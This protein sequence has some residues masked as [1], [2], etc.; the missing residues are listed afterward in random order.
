MRHTSV[1][2]PDC[3][4]T[5]SGR[6]SVATLARAWVFRVHRLATVATLIVLP[7]DVVTADDPQ[8]AF[9][10]NTRSFLNSHCVK[11]HGTRVQ[12]ADLTLHDLG[13]NLRDAQT[14]A[15]WQRVFEQVQLDNMPPEDERR[16]NAGKR[17]AF[18]E[19]LQFELAHAGIELDNERLLRPEFGNYV[20][21]DKLF[22]GSI[23]ALPATVSRVWLNKNVSDSSPGEFRDF[24]ALKRLDEATT[25]RDLREIEKGLE[26]IIAAIK[27]NKRWL[28]GGYPMA[29]IV[30]SRH[31]G[32]DVI[33]LFGKT[34]ASREVIEAD[35]RRAFEAMRRPEPS[36]EQL[37]YYA[38][39]VQRV[40]E[41]RGNEAGFRALLMALALDPS[42]LYRSELGRGEVD[43]H[44][45]RML[46]VQEIE[47][48]Y[49][50]RFGRN[51]LYRSNSE[52]LLH[53][54]DGID[55]VARHVVDSSSAMNAYRDFFRQY[56]GYT[57]ALDVFKGE[58]HARHHLKDKEM[59]AVLV[60]ELEAMI[61]RTLVEDRDVL[62]R[63]LTTDRIFVT[64]RGV[65]SSYDRN[66]GITSIRWA[67]PGQVRN[68]I[69][70]KT[71]EYR[72]D[73]FRDVADWARKHAV[74]DWGWH[75][76]ETRESNPLDRRHTSYHQRF[77]QSH[78]AYLDYYGLEPTQQDIDG[79]AAQSV[80]L[81]PQEQG[82]DKPPKPQYRL[83]PM[84]S[85]VP[86]AGVLTHPAWLLAKS[87]FDHSDVVR[88]GKWIR[89]KLLGGTIP[90]VQIGRASYRERV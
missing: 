33:D 61:Y 19:T 57:D 85:P 9:E 42:S 41:Q 67:A 25:Q 56:F 2:Y 88:R 48:A 26:K 45:R 81:P 38:G 44:G 39:F 11:C 73:K 34:P 78:F 59:A 18:L 4:R 12:E 17:K 6:S 76:V 74:F 63:L 72:S 53:T 89:E 28:N 37:A 54:R 51:S 15:T 49:A 24:A 68:P 65:Q 32:E 3:R 58:R 46:S 86:R 77:A 52:K 35:V 66:N 55:Q 79:F 10:S 43:K 64:G 90:D 62:R 20:D 7:S 69:E 23:T 87:G 71:E 75:L 80:E 82:K 83:D 30:R 27:E 22:D 5:P 13:S 14:A 21:H 50:Y 60:N 1:L 31:N 84:K 29:E 36:E 40:I 8:A 70:K 47:D 16:P